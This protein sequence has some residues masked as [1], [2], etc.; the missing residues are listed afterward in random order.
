MFRL[1]KY[2]FKLK[3]V[4]VKVDKQHFSKNEFL[5]FFKL[6]DKNVLLEKKIMFIFNYVSVVNGLLCCT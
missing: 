1:V 6:F 2:F 4:L 5:V 3:H